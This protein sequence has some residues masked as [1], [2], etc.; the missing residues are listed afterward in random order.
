M[1]YSSENLQFRNWSSIK[2]VICHQHASLWNKI[3]LGFY[4]MNFIRKLPSRC[5]FRCVFA[6]HVMRI[7]KG[8]RATS[9][10]LF[11][12]IFQTNFHFNHK[13]TQ[14]KESRFMTRHLSE[15]ELD[16]LKSH[17]TRLPHEYFE[18][19]IAPARGP[20]NNHPNFSLKCSFQC[21]CLS[22]GVH[23]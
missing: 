20:K 8:F 16:R 12:G 19:K 22:Y 2:F 5:S 4:T 15:E 18:Q 14:T 7:K 3:Y 1:H 11:D 9:G 21:N 6:Q 13:I 23:R 10:K 17:Q